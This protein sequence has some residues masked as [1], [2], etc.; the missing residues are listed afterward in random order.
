MRWE[1]KERS[2]AYWMHAKRCT[3]T[4]NMTIC[5]T[6]VQTY[7]WRRFMTACHNSSMNEVAALTCGRVGVAHR[8]GRLFRSELF[9]V[10]E[11]T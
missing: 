6:T 2:A 3:T 11:H 1:A 4:V 9:G 8:V 7:G 5:R 10:K